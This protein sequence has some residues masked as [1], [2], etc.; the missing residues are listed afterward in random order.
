MLA[1]WNPDR[2]TIVETD[3]SGF[4]LGGCLSQIDKYG[5]L[6]PVAYHSRRLNSAEVNHQIHDKEMLAIISCLQ[7]WQA[8]L[9]SISKPFT[10]FTDHKNLSYFTTKRLLNERQVRYNDLIQK[11]N[12]VLKW[13]P[14]NVC[15][16]PDALSRREQ[17][18]I[19]GL[20]D[21][22]TAGRVMRLLPPV[23]VSPANFG[24]NTE[25]LSLQFDP[26]ALT[27]LFE[28]DKL[29]NLWKEGVMADKDWQRARDAVSAGER[30]F[31]PDLALKL[32]ANIAECTVASD[33]VLRG[34]E[35]RI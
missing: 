23:T 8:E 4:A 20:N 35:N 27:R 16:R 15:E 33:S 9:Q 17:D 30:S 22:R 26:A 3:C 28:E 13:R 6:R 19:K 12:F 5:N 7:E 32:K 14:G 21:E 1:Q 18:M 24:D 34:R 11:F 31:P 10:A 29:Q 25:E 2:E